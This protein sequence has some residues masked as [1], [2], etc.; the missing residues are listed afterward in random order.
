M[1]EFSYLSVLLSIIIGLAV[2]QILLG[3]R[4]RMLSHAR[5]KP[6][7]PTQAWAAIILLVSTQTWWAMF[8]YR[9]RHDWNFVQFLI[10]LAQAI[11]LYLVAGL[12]Y[13]DFPEGQTIDLEEHF[14]RQRKRF[15]G[16]LALTTVI[17]FFRDPIF[18][19]RLTDPAN[20]GFHVLFFT[21]SL[22]ACFIANLLYHKIMTLVVA[23]LF[24]SYIVVLFVQLH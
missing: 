20:L 15:F 21:L 7:W 13:P 4:G 19:H 2:T 6:F 22:A 17:S 23:L 11:V 3:V 5:I 18:D 12:V 1:D 8:G 16:L 10:L 14:L 9:S 24:A